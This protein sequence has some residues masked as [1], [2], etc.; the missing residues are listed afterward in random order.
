MNVVQSAFP[1]GTG[2]VASGNEEVRT[3]ENQHQAVAYYEVAVGTDR[4]YPK[5]RDNTV[6]FTNVGLNKTWTFYHLDLKPSGLYYVTV[7]AYS[8]SNAM[9]EVTSNGIQVGF[10]VAVTAGE[11]VIPEYAKSATTLTVE[12]AGF[13]STLDMYIYYMGVS[14]TPLSVGTQCSDLITDESAV[15]ALF[16]VFPVRLMEKDTFYI[17]HDL[18]MEHNNT[19]Y[20]TV[21]GVDEAG[22]CNMSTSSFLVDLTEPVEGQVRV[23]PLYGQ[24]LAYVVTR[25][26]ITVHWEGY[27]DP[28][29]DISYFELVLYSAKSCSVSDEDSLS[30]ISHVTVNSSFTFYTFLELTLQENTPYYVELTAFNKAGRETRTRSVPVIYDVQETTAGDVH[31]GLDFIRDV[32]FVGSTTEVEGSILHLADPG[33]DKGCPDRPSLFTDVEWSTVKTTNFWGLGEDWN[34]LFRSKQ[35]VP[36]E[37]G[38][39]VAITIERDVQS[40]QMFSGAIYRNADIQKGGTYKVD[41]KAGASDFSA[42]TAVVFWDGPDGTVGDF[43]VCRFCCQNTEDLVYLYMCP[44]DCLMHLAFPTDVPENITLT[45]ETYT[46]QVT[47]ETQQDVPKYVVFEDKVEGE[48]FQGNEDDMF[49]TQPACG[50]QIHTNGVLDSKIVLWCQYYDNEY[51]AKYE[52][53]DSLNFDPSEEWHT[54]KFVFKSSSREGL[55]DWS[56]ELLIDNHEKAVVSGL[57]AFSDGTKLIFDQWNADNTV[58][59]LEFQFKPPTATVLFRNLV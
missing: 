34:I 31:V 25:E 54:Y 7:R 26:S 2:S 37:D 41:I 21:V 51:L 27:Y 23:G 20:V 42:I 56:L 28:E 33:T 55:D 30:E 5:T 10:D 12:W 36:T 8:T 43:D 47:S 49:T 58:P 45:V 46:E 44:C 32:T 52:T 40:P 4:T 57:P 17:A 24:K 15:R 39:G 6:E 53:V 11:V 13:E 48:T 35:V 19:Y 9:V 16:G 3:D 38:R 29:S 18:S 14:S 50:M 59:E 22:E 1:N